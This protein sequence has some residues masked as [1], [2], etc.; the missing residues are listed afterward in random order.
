[1]NPL[2]F[3]PNAVL[4]GI[5]DAG[6][7]SAYAFAPRGEMEEEHSAAAKLFITRMLDAAGS[8]AVAHLAGTY[9]SCLI[10]CAPGG[11]AAPMVAWVLT[12]LMLIPLLLLV[13]PFVAILLLLLKRLRLKRKSTFAAAGSLAGLLALVTLKYL[14]PTLWAEI[15]PA[16]MIVA[17]TAGGAT[18]G[19]LYRLTATLPKRTRRPITSA[20]AESGAIALTTSGGAVLRLC[21]LIQAAHESLSASRKRT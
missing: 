11:W 12:S 10:V 16:L 6:I 14:A 20:R 19:F 2:V 5:L 9:V 8:F 13:S 21:A 18:G 7:L 4:A 1:L 3:A 15:N 17:A